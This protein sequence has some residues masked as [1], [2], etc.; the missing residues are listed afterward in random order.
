M[1]NLKDINTFGK[2]VKYLPCT[3]L[4]ACLPVSLP[5]G[6]QCHQFFVFLSR[7]I[8]CVCTHVCVCVHAWHVGGSLDSGY[9][10]IYFYKN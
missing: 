2:T 4:S 6:S 3:A 1:S 10:D 8:L 7:D 9:I 5:G